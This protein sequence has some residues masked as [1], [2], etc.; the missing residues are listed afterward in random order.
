MGFSLSMDAAVNACLSS[1]SRLDL[2]PSS[3]ALSLWKNSSIVVC[4]TAFEGVL[5]AVFLIL[6]LLFVASK[7]HASTENVCWMDSILGGFAVWASFEFRVARA[8]LRAA[9]F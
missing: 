3:S 1:L 9:C 5:R 6:A 2:A 4:D 8:M 7:S